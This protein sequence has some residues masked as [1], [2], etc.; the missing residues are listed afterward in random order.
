[1]YL[2][3][4]RFDS[5]YRRIPSGA[6]MRNAR[7]ISHNGARAGAGVSAEKGRCEKLEYQVGIYV[8]IGD[9]LYTIQCVYLYCIA[10]NGI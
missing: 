5:F 2:I 1:M 4:W 7:L 8:E 3:F 6:P 9:N 10:A